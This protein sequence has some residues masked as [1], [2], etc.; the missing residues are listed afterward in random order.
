MTSKSQYGSK[1]QSVKI[2]QP[3]ISGQQKALPNGSIEVKEKVQLLQT[4]V[5]NGTK[6]NTNGN[7]NGVCSSCSCPVPTETTTVIPSIIKETQTNTTT[8]VPPA[9]KEVTS[10][11]KNPYPPLSNSTKTTKEIG[12]QTDNPQVNGGNK[13]DGSTQ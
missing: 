3:P 6:G 9:V 11:I 1:Q 5:K 10:P 8:K 2:A 12:A 13:Q 4:S 7:T